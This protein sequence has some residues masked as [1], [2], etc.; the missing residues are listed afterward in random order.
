VGSVRGVAQL[1]ES[2][3]FGS[4]RSAVQVRPPRLSIG[5]IVKTDTVSRQGRGTYSK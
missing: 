2:A 1:G 4:V 5:R 3:R